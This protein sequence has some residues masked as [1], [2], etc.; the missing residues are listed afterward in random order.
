MAILAMLEHG[1]D[2]R[3]TSREVIIRTVASAGILQL[4]AKHQGPPLTV[5]GPWPIFTAFPFVPHTWREPGLG[6][7]SMSQGCDCQTAGFGNSGLGSS[8]LGIKN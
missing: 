4:P 7:Q 2:A 5:A 8:G 3:G 1:Q 6:V